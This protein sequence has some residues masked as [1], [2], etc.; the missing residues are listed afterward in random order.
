MES[1]HDLFVNELRDLYNAEIQIVKALP[2]L[3]TAA[4]SDELR[5][6]LE[7]PLE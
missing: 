7:A 6:A 5:Q 1:L 2:K 3:I 4:S